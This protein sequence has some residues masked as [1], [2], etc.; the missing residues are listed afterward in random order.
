MV[1]QFPD[2]GAA[3]NGFHSRSFHEWEA[4]ALHEAN[5]PASPDMR[6][7][8]AWRLS[9]GGVPVPPPPSD[10]ECH[11]KI[12]CIRAS[13]P[14]HARQEERYA[15]HNLPMWTAYF[16]RRYTDQLAFTNGFPASRW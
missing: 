8:G 4:Q 3:A 5:Y 12:V 7:P 6:M 10:K 9:V 1:E 16:Q 15:A 14:E 11:S 13:L 2:Y